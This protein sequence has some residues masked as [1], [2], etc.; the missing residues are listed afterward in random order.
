MFNKLLCNLVPEGAI[1]YCNSVTFRMTVQV[2][3]RDVVYCSYYVS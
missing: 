2:S 3:G 1:D